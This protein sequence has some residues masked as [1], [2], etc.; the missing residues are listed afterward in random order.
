M[1]LSIFKKLGIREVQPI[2]VSLQLADRSIK[3]PRGVLENMLVKMDKFI[4]LMVFIVLD[5]EEDREVPL[6]LG[7]PFLAIGRALIDVEEGKLELCVQKKK[8]IFKVF[9]VITPPFKPNSC[10]RA[11]IMEANLSSS[12]PHHIPLLLGSL[13]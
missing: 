3:H 9:E 8:V 1:P 4:F 12:I 6:I 13:N 7:K 2:I 11:D 10:F 5:M